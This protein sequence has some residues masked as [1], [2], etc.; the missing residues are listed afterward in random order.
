MT[1]TSPDGDLGPL[2][3]F[4]PRKAN[5][6]ARRGYDDAIPL[7]GGDEAALITQDGRLGKPNSR[8]DAIHDPRRRFRR[9]GIRALTHQGPGLRLRIGPRLHDRDEVAN[10]GGIGLIVSV[11]ILGATDSLLQDR[12]S[13]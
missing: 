5:R 9:V 8:L 2:L 13:E 3:L 10:L 4:K 7:E 1:R 12:V 11:V 6:R